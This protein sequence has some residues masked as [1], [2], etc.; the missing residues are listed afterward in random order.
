MFQFYFK[1]KF[2]ALKMFQIPSCEKNATSI[3][4]ICFIYLYN[5][6]KRISG[7]LNIEAK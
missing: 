7:T 1:E 3:G 2:D 5:I 4:F 6:Y